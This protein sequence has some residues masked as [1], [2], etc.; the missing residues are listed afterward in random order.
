MFKELSSQH[1]AW[2]KVW[3]TQYSYFI[4]LAYSKV[5]T[6]WLMRELQSIGLE[7]YEQKYQFD[8]P[9]NLMNN[10]TAD[11]TNVYALLRAPRAAST[12]AMVMT[13]PLR[14]VDSGMAATDGSVAL[15]LS[16]AKY[17]ISRWLYTILYWA[18][19]KMAFS[20]AAFS[21]HVVKILSFLI[22]LSMMILFHP[23]TRFKMDDLSGVL[24]EQS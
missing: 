17:M 6:D 23:F 5:P 24:V 20:I 22:F 4:S 1:H 18:Y 14:P 3:K 11:G 21:L 12:E 8:Y 10:R 16:L 2:P 13:A 9:M 19:L 7:V 15:M